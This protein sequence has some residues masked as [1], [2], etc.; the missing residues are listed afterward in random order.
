[1]APALNR[2]ILAAASPGEV[3][4][5][6]VEQDRLLDYA[7]WRPGAPDGVGD[8]YRGRVIARVASMA[9]TF[10]AV[11]GSTGF[12]PDS[13]TETPLTEGT[14][15]AVRITRAAQADKGPR[16]T[17]RLSAE[18]LA[19]GGSGAQR[20]IRRG[21][22]AVERLAML[23]PDASVMIDDPGLAAALQPA[24]S[25]RIEPVPQA[26]DDDTELQ[27]EALERSS[28]VLPG[29]GRLSVHPTPALV[30]IDLD[31]G[32]ATA[33]GFGKAAAQLAFN[34]AALP[35]LAREIRLRNLSGAIM[36]DLAGLPA[37]RRSL[38]APAFATALASDPLAPRLLGFTKLGLAEIVRRRIHPP[39][40]E[41]ISGPHAAGLLALRRIAA[42]LARPPHRLPVLVAAPAIVAALQADPVA[43]PDLAKRAGRPLIFRSDPALSSW[44]LEISDG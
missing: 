22:G 24:L 43:L 42:E 11:S 30:A 9:G 3:R 18:E 23:H 12:L 28:V 8:L 44:R 17:A 16:L 37:R 40:H 27:I 10:V 38:L 34:R 41:L 26:F 20:L 7:I 6:V 31:S 32:Q 14:L 25:C 2:R 36:V 21:P 19:L 35:E 5:A 39:L 13:E 1:M 33:D 29:G 4:T 15:L